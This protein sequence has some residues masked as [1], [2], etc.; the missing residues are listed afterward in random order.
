MIKKW[1]TGKKLIKKPE[2]SP[3]LLGAVDYCQKIAAMQLLKYAI[4]FF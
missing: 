3:A 2:L 1:N 4:S